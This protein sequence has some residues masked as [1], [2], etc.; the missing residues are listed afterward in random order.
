VHTHVCITILS[1][2]PPYELIEGWRDAKAAVQRVRLALD[3]ERVR[4]KQHPLMAVDIEGDL[5]EDG[6]LSLIQIKVDG[7]PPMIFDALCN[8][9]GG[10][11]TEGLDN[12]LE[13]PTVIKVM[14]DCRKDAVALFG[15]LGVRLASVYDTQ[16]T[17]GA[18]N[19]DP[20][21]ALDIGALEWLRSVLI[22]DVSSHC[23]GCVHDVASWC[24]PTRAQ[25]DHKRALRW[26][27]QRAQGRRYA[28]R[29]SLGEAPC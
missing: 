3:Q 12:L 4:S 13:D 29:R 22:Y 11:E 16:V 9:H 8:P 27:P 20:L 7:L 21:T 15:Q 17:H 26:P 10:V 23:S 5:G 19:A 1:A 2:M 24:A 25:R 14:H 18:R 28:L 6:R